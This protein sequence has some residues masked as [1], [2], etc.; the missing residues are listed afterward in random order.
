MFDIASK[1]L[2]LD[3]LVLQNNSNGKSEESGDN[4]PELSKEQVSFFLGI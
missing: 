4:E 3:H 1:K 2:A